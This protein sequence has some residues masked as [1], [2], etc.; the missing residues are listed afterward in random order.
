MCDTDKMY[1]GVLHMPMSGHGSDDGV[2][3]EQGCHDYYEGMEMCLLC[4]LNG[5]QILK[6]RF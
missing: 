4:S 3:W 2:A 5:T 1:F 6:K